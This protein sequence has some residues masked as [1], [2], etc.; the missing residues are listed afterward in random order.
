MITKPADRKLDDNFP[1]AQFVDLNEDD[2]LGKPSFDRLESG[3]EVG[4]K[5]YLFGTTV[6]DKFDYEEVN[7]STPVEPSLIVV[8]GLHTAAHAAWALDMGAAGR[9][10][11]RARSKLRPETEVKVKVNPPP[12]QTLDA[13]AGTMNGAALTG[14]AAQSFWTAQD[15]A[16]AAGPGVHVVEAFEMSF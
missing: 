4:Q 1:I 6:A 9:S 11:L 14:R 8:A 7:L 3:F 10:E 12:L 5:D 16:S 2:L 13:G 15:V